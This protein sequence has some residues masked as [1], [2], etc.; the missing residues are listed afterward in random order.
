METDT[1]TDTE[2]DIVWTYLNPAEPERNHKA[3]TACK[4]IRNDCI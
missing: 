3:Q 1:E 2:T 4:V